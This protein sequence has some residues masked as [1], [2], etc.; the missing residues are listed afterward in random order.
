MR[1]RHFAGEKLF[2]DY[3]GAQRATLPTSTRFPAQCVRGTGST[4]DAP[5]TGDALCIRRVDR[6]ARRLSI[7]MLTSTATTK[8]AARARRS[9]GVGA[10]LCRHSRG[11]LPRRTCGRSRAF[12]PAWPSHAGHACVANDL[13]NEIGR[14][15]D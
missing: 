15:V 1:Q 6:S 13:F 5:A 9:L 11:L 14:K 10:L 3:A 2:V 4:G 12:I 8:R 7:T